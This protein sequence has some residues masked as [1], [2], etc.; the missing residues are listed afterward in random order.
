MELQHYS[1]AL[2]K[3]RLLQPLTVDSQS[4]LYPSLNIPLA[5]PRKPSRP[6]Q[7]LGRT[8]PCS[9]RRAPS[10]PWKGGNTTGCNVSC[11]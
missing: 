8:N 2:Q 3:C 5:L 9:Y 1:L 6:V 10:C 7:P 4:C 11:S